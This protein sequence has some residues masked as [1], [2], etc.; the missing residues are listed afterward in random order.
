[1][2][3]SNGGG[4]TIVSTYTFVIFKEGAGGKE[5]EKKEK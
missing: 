3:I 4:N 2:A 5:K 1:M